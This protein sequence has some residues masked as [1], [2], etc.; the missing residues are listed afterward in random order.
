MKDLLFVVVLYE[1]KIEES[2]TLLSFVKIKYSYKN[3][4]D[5]Y[6]K[7]NSKTPMLN[8]ADLTC[9]G[10]V[11]GKIDYVYNNRNDS[12]S[13]IYNNAI[14]ICRNKYKF[15]VLFD[16]DSL[17]SEKYIDVVLKYTNN[18]L[19]F[20]CLILPIVKLNNRIVSPAKYCF[21]SGKS[22][23]K[24][25]CG[26]QNSRK[27]AAINSGMIIPTSYFEKYD[28]LYDTNLKFYGTDDFFMINYSKNES[29]LVIMDFEMFH[30]LSL[31]DNEISNKEKYEK[32]KNIISA[33][34]YLNNGSMLKIL[35]LKFQLIFWFAKLNIFYKWKY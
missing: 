1:K 11:F 15:V 20:N 28:F 5:L 33:S 29:R 16:D 2:N 22:L 19:F 6:I 12:L 26:L 18:P 4:C 21:I 24:I 35:L 32:I 30:N 3:K 23:K 27:I 8:S 9:M 25:E 10:D 13:E 14:S 7:D 17:F 34:V 31:Y